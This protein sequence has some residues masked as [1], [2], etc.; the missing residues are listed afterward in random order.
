MNPGSPLLGLEQRGRQ[1]PE[2][3]QRPA[4]DLGDFRSPGSEFAFFFFFCE[5]MVGPH[6]AR[7]ILEQAVFS[8]DHGKW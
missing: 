7:R 1:L 6:G 8:E 3:F 2:A 4:K 5:Q